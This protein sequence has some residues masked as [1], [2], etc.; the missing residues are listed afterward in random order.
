V[1]D[2]ACGLDIL[3]RNQIRNQRSNTK[4]TI[5]LEVRIFSRKQGVATARDRKGVIISYRDE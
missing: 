4:N 1:Q 3:N 2:H 5:E